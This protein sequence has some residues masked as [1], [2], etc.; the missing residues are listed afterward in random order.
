MTCPICKKKGHSKFGCHE[1][2][3]T[4]AKSVKVRLVNVDKDDC[5]PT[6]MCT[7]EFKTDKGRVFSKEV[8]PVMGCSQTIITENL[9]KT[10]R[11]F[12]DRK[13]KKQIWNAS[14]EHMLCRGTATFEVSYGSQTTKVSALVSPDLEDDVLLGWRGLQRLKIIPD[15]FPNPMKTEEIVRAA[16]VKTDPKAEI[17]KTMEKF[18]KVF[19]E[20]SLEGG[21]LKPMKVGQ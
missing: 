16:C 4:D 21:K 13:K 7:M 11:M 6:P 17:E 9:A 2:P 19:D 18:P 8:L 14:N 12:V 15:N 3:K 10:N 20:P 1:K 5:E